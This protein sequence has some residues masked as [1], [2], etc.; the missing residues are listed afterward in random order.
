MQWFMSHTKN[1]LLEKHARFGCHVAPSQ[2][3]HF[4]GTS[5]HPMYH[6]VKQHPPPHPSSSLKI[7]KKNCVFP[8]IPSESLAPSSRYQSWEWAWQWAWEPSCTME[9]A[10]EPCTLGWPYTSK[11]HSPCWSLFGFALFRFFCWMSIDPPP[12]EWSSLKT[13]IT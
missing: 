7:D 5:V 8:C 10:F 11:K 13:I 6:C 2:I 9:H 4:Q 1:I 12:F 3:V